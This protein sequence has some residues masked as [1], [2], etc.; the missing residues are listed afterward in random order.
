MTTTREFIP[1]DIN[2]L[3]SI[4]R[5]VNGDDF[6]M[7]LIDLMGVDAWVMLCDGTGNDR[8]MVGGWSTST[9]IG[10]VMR[11]GYTT[12]HIYE[13]LER[14]NLRKMAY[15]R[16]FD[17]HRV[18]VGHKPLCGEMLSDREYRSREDWINRVGWAR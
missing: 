9:T 7:T 2:Q 3:L 16:H 15:A 14:D 8:P 10:R 17:H 13:A 12:A 5:H 18:A 1:C 4:L 6:H 11:L